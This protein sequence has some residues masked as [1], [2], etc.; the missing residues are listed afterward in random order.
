LTGDITSAPCHG[1]HRA[2]GQVLTC[3]L[4]SFRESDGATEQVGSQ[5]LGDGAPSL[6][7]CSLP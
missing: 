1:G 4:A 2:T 6:L 5:A 3:Q 7:L